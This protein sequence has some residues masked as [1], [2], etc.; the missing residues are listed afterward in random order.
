ML[1]DYTISRNSLNL[2]Y[3]TPHGITTKKIQLD[4]NNDNFIYTTTNKK[5]ST[6]NS[7]TGK[8]LK[9]DTVTKIDDFRVC[10]ILNTLIDSDIY[11]PLKSSNYIICNL[12]HESVT[13]T[14]TYEFLIGHK[15]LFVLT[16]NQKYN[17][18][19]ISITNK[20]KVFNNLIS[21]NTFIK[22]VILSRYKNVITPNKMVYDIFTS[23]F[24]DCN[25]FSLQFDDLYYYITNKQISYINTVFDISKYIQNDKLLDIINEQLRYTKIPY[26]KLFNPLKT[27]EFII[28]NELIAN[29]LKIERN[30]K[31]KQ[32]TTSSKGG[33]IYLKNK[34]VYS[35]VICLDFKSMYPAI[36]RTFNIPIVKTKKTITKTIKD[37][38]VD[39]YYEQTPNISNKI[40]DYI[41]FMRNNT[42]TDIT[43]L[44][45][46]LL[47]NKAYGCFAN[48]NFKFYDLDIS[49]TITGFGRVLIKTLSKYVNKHIHTILDDINNHLKS[50]GSNVVFEEL[51]D[52]VIYNH[53]D[54]L[55]ISL[56]GDIINKHI[57]KDLYDVVISPFINK[58]IN[59]FV[60]SFDV[61]HNHLK[62]EVEGIYDTVLFMA[63][64]QYIA[65][66]PTDFII[67][68]G[69]LINKNTPK[70]TEKILKDTISNIL[71]NDLNKGQITN[72]VN[73]IYKLYKMQPLHL[74]SK[75]VNININ[76]KLN[77][78]NDRDKI[79]LAKNKKLSKELRGCV[80][81]N[82]LVQKNNL[83]KK[84]PLIIDG[85]QSIYSYPLKNHSYLF[86]YPSNVNPH[87]VAPTPDFRLMFEED[88]IQP[89]NKILR[90]LN[91]TP[92][93]N[94]FI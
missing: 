12:I 2:L 24:Q 33:Y 93:N 74:I 31:S 46:K 37:L 5:T 61:A 65:I 55:M 92:L 10:E 8:R 56:G 19:N 60:S 30:Y 22:R 86:C 83:T 75:K 29:N 43:N 91:I 52:V 1:I 72:R 48:N 59:A 51:K 44:T 47:Q 79:V 87:L 45:Y 64:N 90:L 26:K 53:T 76:Y 38:G 7:I 84:L 94:F 63:K 89:L 82:H 68:G 62:L 13:N 11:E 18:P 3:T 80:I 16:T 73:T 66:T 36:I 58:Y 35:N 40:F 70:Y 78:I 88:Y 42:S 49:N 15:I 71:R 14:Y 54:S 81:Y 77:V 34:G 32:N 25:V 50:L 28:Y 41:Q 67:K 85:V 17:P 57:L 4:N 69:G 27:T 6:L 39:L 20:M 21:L 23:T 9:K